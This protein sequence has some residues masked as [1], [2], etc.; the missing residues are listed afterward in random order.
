MCGK[1]SKGKTMSMSALSNTKN[2]PHT[3]L[4]LV[5][6][7]PDTVYHGMKDL[8]K[9]AIDLLLDCPARYKAW[10]DSVESAPTDAM[11]F[12]SM[13]H[14]LILEPETFDEEYAVTSHPGNTKIGK[15]YRAEMRR[16]G[17]NVV[18]KKHYDVAVAMAEA[19]RSHPQAKHLFAHEETLTE[20]AFFWSESGIRC[21]GKADIITENPSGLYVGDIKTCECAS[22]EHIS[23]A[24]GE[25]HYHRQAAWYLRGLRSVGVEVTAFIFVFVEKKPPHLVTCVMADADALATGESECLTALDVLKKCR[26]TGVYPGYS[27]AVE[28]I[29]L[30]Q[31]ALRRNEEEEKKWQQWI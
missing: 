2:T 27:D 20:T 3:I 18:D 19:V 13:C 6:D 1:A 11:A 15:E 10:L 24:M 14:K 16:N 29:K 21:K 26:M 28:E 8:S 7:M 9:S 17:L 5:P 23:K 22:L 25:W 12:G 4:G 30:P 31:W